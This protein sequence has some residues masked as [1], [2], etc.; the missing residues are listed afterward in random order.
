M[1]KTPD[2]KNLHLRHYRYDKFDNRLIVS[3]SSLFRP[4]CDVTINPGVRWG[5]NWYLGKEKKLEYKTLYPRHYRYGKFVSV[6]SFSNFAI[7]WCP[8]WRH[9]PPGVRWDKFKC[10]EYFE[11][12]VGYLSFTLIRTG[13]HLINAFPSIPLYTVSGLSSRLSHPKAEQVAGMA[14]DIYGILLLVNYYFYNFTPL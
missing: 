13:I 14:W 12:K 8:L 5:T 4:Y 1:E 2:L 7:F 9:K 10:Y 3:N 6:L 11:G